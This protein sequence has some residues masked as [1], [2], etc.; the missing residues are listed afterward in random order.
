LEDE[1]A[2]AYLI[3][4]L[5]LYYN[6]EPEEDADPLE[7]KLTTSFYQPVTTLYSYTAKGRSYNLLS[8]IIEKSEIS[9]DKVAMLTPTKSTYTKKRP[10]K[11]SEKT[12]SKAL[13]QSTLGQGRYSKK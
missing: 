2:A 11:R 4:T 13:Q 5:F 1:L 12:V 9:I 10:S 3:A 6:K 7:D 8:N